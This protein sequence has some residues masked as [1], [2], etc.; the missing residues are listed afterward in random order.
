MAGMMNRKLGIGAFNI[1]QNY[2]II[3]RVFQ[4]T[5]IACPVTAK[6]F[7]MVRGE[8]AK[9]QLHLCPSVLVRR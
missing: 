3:N 9:N 8:C 6:Y 7:L 2:K 4:E 5:F 1:L